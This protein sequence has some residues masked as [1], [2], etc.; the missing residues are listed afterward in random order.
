VRTILTLVAAA[1]FVAGAA[2]QEDARKLG[3]GVTAPVLVREVKPQYTKDARDRKVQGTVEMEC[4]VDSD[5]SVRDD[6]AVTKSLDPAL[7]EQA[8]IALKQWRFRPGTFHDKP[9][10]VKVNIEMTFTLKERAGK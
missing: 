6:I 3:D 5:G 2:A 4:V 9:V 8:I 7:D 10:P 1:A